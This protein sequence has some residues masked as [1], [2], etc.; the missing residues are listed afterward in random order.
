[1]GWLNTCRELFSAKGL[2][3]GGMSV[4]F[5]IGIHRMSA[6]FIMIR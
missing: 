2:R 1:M 4:D 6:V 5:I 3:V